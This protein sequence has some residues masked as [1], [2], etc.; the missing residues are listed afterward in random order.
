[1]KFSG[2]V[3]YRVA[4]DRLSRECDV[5]VLRHV[6]SPVVCDVIDPKCLTVNWDSM[7]LR[8]IGDV[9]QVEVTT[10]GSAIDGELSC[11]VTGRRFMCLVSLLLAVN[12]LTLVLWSRSETSTM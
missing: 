3:T 8:R 10:D 9:V 2:S 7:T 1:M 12:F 6:G 5:G 4:H 11:S